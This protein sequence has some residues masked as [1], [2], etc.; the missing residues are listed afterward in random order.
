MKYL[1][2]TTEIYRADSEAEAIKI[3]EDAKADTHYVLSK[4]SSQYKE[5]KQKGEVVDSWYKVSLT[6]SFTDEKEPQFE[7]RVEYTNSMESAF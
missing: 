4:Y 7:T 1:I 5:R 6:K 2:S 3:I